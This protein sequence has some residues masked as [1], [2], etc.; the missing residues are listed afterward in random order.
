M[1]NVLLEYAKLKSTEIWETY[2]LFCRFLNT[3]F[4]NA[5]IK[6]LLFNLTQTFI[7]LS[8]LGCLVRILLSL[9]KTYSFK[10]S[11]FI[12]VAFWIQP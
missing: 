6:L 7:E 9:T 4:F 3:T 1:V 8:S 12:M 10:M 2:Y 5:K 11:R